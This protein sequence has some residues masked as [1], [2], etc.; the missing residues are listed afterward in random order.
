MQPLHLI[1]VMAIAIEA[2]IAEWKALSIGNKAAALLKRTGGQ[3]VMVLGLPR[4][5]ERRNNV[6]VLQ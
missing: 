4:P 3:D 6:L 2:D 5:I 1:H